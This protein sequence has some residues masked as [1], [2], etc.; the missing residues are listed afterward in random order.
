M[1]IN[2]KVVG[3]FFYILVFLCVS[4]P[5][6]MPD[7]VIPTRFEPVAWKDSMIF[8]ATNDGPCQVQLWD[9]ETRTLV[10]RYMFSMKDRYMTIGDMTVDKERFWI[11][12]DGKNETLVQVDVASG[13]VNKIALDIRPNGLHYVGG[14]LWV[15][16]PDT[17]SLKGFRVRRLNRDGK[18]E[19]SMTINRHDIE[20]VP[21][22]ST[23]YVDGNFFVPIHTNPDAKNVD[24]C[25]YIANLSRGGVLTKIPLETLYP[26]PLLENLGNVVYDSIFYPPDPNHSAL[27]WYKDAPGYAHVLFTECTDTWHW[28]YKVESYMPL[29]LS[30]SPIITYHRQ[31]D[32]SGWYISQLGEH[33]FV[34][35]RLARQ[36]DD[37]PEYYGL[38]IGVYPK[39]GGEELS[40]FRLRNSN[41][42]TYAK[43]NGET[44]FAKNIW[45]W[46]YEHDKWNL[47]GETEAYILDEIN[48]KLYRVKADGTVVLVQ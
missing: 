36:M 25:F 26:G 41:Q 20:F 6:S 7:D 3:A 24:N 42:I 12:L 47:E 17:P 10:R 4:C 13:K 5:T 18:L 45:S 38:E 22:K 16:E 40:F 23:I 21:H 27:Y 14:A 2:F 48:V 44:W 30:S 11:S 29:Q 31:G 46:D 37:E 32:R 9:T 8:L 33:L 1:H 28:Y 35:G 15:F 34:G 43:R 39:E 19:L